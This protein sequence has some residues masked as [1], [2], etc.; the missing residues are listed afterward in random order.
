MS[1]CIPEGN[2]GCSHLYPSTFYIMVLRHC[3]AEYSKGVENIHWSTGV[4]KKIKDECAILL[5][6]SIFLAFNFGCIMESL[7]K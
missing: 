7:N 3:V 5:Q 2:Q 4:L 1:V 6:I